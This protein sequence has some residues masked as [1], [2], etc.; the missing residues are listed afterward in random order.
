MR[1]ALAGSVIVVLA[2]A[3]CSGTDEPVSDAGVETPN[4]TETP[5]V[6]ESLDDDAIEVEIEGDEVMP[7]GKRIKVQ[8]AQTILLE[9]KSDRPGELH[10]HSTPEQEIAFKEGGST[11]ELTVETPGIVDVEEH[12]SGVVI[13]QLEVS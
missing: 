12:E 6:S 1:Q 13:L 5:G 9:I 4:A 11:I 8:T 2:L 7:N 10:V 3:G